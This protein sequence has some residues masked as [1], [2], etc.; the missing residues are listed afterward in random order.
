MIIYDCA[1]KFIFC[2]FV[3]RL[4]EQINFL[5]PTQK[6]KLK[7][8]TVFIM[9]GVFIKN[10]YLG[11]WQTIDTLIKLFER[12]ESQLWNKESHE[13]VDNQCE[14][15][16]IPIKNNIN[17]LQKQTEKYNIFNNYY[18]SKTGKRGYNRNVFHIAAEV[19]NHK[20]VSGYDSKK[21]WAMFR[22]DI[23]KLSI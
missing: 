6:C 16:W 5:L 21:Q 22:A 11:D 3:G 8:L 10:C 15:E 14:H 7:L 19:I 23:I 13:P 17:S 2:Q 4:T 12:N 18:W 20:R 9:G 1:K